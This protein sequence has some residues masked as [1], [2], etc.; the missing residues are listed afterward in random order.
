MNMS[1]Y[2]FS[3]EKGGCPWDS[4]LVGGK[5]NFFGTTTKPCAMSHACAYREHEPRR[6]FQSVLV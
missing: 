1:L 4:F 5:E 2:N 6:F 3:L